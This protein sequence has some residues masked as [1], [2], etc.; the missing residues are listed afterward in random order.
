MMSTYL[1]TASEQAAVALAAFVSRLC[2]GFLSSDTAVPIQQLLTTERAVPPLPSHPTVVVLP[3]SCTGSSTWLICW[4]SS[5]D[6]QKK[7][8]DWAEARRGDAEVVVFFLFVWFLCV[9][10]VWFFFL[11]IF[12]PLLLVK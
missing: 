8:L 12:S 7:I 6:E 3:L 11:F 1:S 10:G 2:G 4:F 9:R 5:L